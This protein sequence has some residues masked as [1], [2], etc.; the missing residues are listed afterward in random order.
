M[1]YNSGMYGDQMHQDVEKLIDHG[2]SST[3]EELRIM[4]EIAECVKNLTPDSRRRVF[5]WCHDYFRIENGRWEP[6]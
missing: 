4:G 5:A 3:E 6:M 1:R 2:D